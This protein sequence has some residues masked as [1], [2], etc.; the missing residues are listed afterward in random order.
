MNVHFAAGKRFFTQNRIAAG[1]WMLQQKRNQALFFCS[2][3][4]IYI[5]NKSIEDN[6]IYITFTISMT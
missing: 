5:S 1:F 4:E 3:C 2:Y 6:I